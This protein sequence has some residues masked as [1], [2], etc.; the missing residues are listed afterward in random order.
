MP[1]GRKWSVDSVQSLE[2]VVLCYHYF[3]S[4]ATETAHALKFSPKYKAGVSNVPS[5]SYDRLVGSSMSTGHSAKK[6]A[7]GSEKAHLY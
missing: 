4:Y 7:S 3:S 1:A 2:S 5:S 6:V